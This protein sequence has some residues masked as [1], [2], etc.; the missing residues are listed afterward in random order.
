MF[1]LGGGPEAEVAEAGKGITKEVLILS[2]PSNM[3]RKEKAGKPPD[4]EE[5]LRNLLLNIPGAI[6][7]CCLDREWTMH[8]MSGGIKEI[9]GYPATDYIGNRV[10]TYESIIS[11]KDRKKVWDVISRAVEKK[12]SYSLEYRIAHK[13]G[14][15]RWVFEK[16]TGIYAGDGSLLF[17]DGVIFDID[18]KKKTE[19]LL[20]ESEENY[21]TLVEGA[22]HNIF[23][24]DEKGVFRFLN[25]H[26][27]KQIGGRPDDYIGKNMWDIFPKECA[28]NQMIKIRESILSEKTLTSKSRATV[29][30]EVRWYETTLQPCKAHPGEERTVIGIATDIT[31]SKKADESLTGIINGLGVPSLVINKEH[32]ITHWNSALE[33]LS[34]IKKESVIGTN[35][36]WSIFYPE[37]RPILADLIVDGEEA[38]IERR[39]GAK[40]KKSTLIPGAYEGIDFFPLQEP[41]NG[42]NTQRHPSETQ[43]G[44]S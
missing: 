43:K 32:I 34:R 20:L 10:R 35:K 26:A 24:V 23:K 40:F 44:I 14:S 9:S 41:V 21:R 11:R 42:C 25:S 5:I 15:E 28:D 3:N 39:Y 37:S 22:N 33:S 17:L 2:K 38:E 30:G 29:K 6:Y 13:N 12:E 27:A 1:E 4:N 7:R 36:Q 18:E 19:E 16:G 31:D 8:Y